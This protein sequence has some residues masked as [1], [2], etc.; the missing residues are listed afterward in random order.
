MDE[1]D[2][3]FERLGALADTLVGE[4]RTG[5][6][7]AQRNMDRFEDVKLVA[8]RRA[9]LSSQDRAH[10]SGYLATGLF[11][12]MEQE[13]RLA[14]FTVVIELDEEVTRRD[15][16]RRFKRYE[17]TQPLFQ[18]SPALWES[19]RKT[20]LIPATM[21]RHLRRSG[22]VEVHGGGWARLDPLLPPE[23]L[24]WTQATFPAASLFV[25]LDPYFFSSSMPAEPLKEAAVRPSRPDW[26]KDLSLRAREKDGGHYELQPPVELTGAT[27][28]QYW[29]YNVRCVRS[30]E[31][32]A[33]RD[34]TENLSMM[35]EELSQER[36]AARMMGRCIH[37]DTDAEPGSPA[38]TA[39]LNHL[40][41]AINVYLDEAAARRK[42]MRLSD[43]KVEDASTR[44]HLLRIE[45]VPFAATAEFVRQF[46]QSTVLFDEWARDQ[47]GASFS[48]ATAE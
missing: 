2:Q 34:K 19:A 5:S 40:D 31:V 17:D 41:L 8:L 25:R 21:F 11:S 12:A 48:A 35:I 22:L 16:T 28:D 6:D 47:L 42:P 29:E 39:T 33:E 36:R 1:A 3:Y 46:F 7:L 30:L 13:D 10:V 26:W 9:L 38:S 20:E 4:G 14:A 23:L 18:L 24:V 45:S 37:L 15:L 44:T 32:Y 27:L 43:G